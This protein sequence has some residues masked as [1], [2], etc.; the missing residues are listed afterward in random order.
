MQRCVGQ[1][2][3]EINSDDDDNKVTQHT[4]TSLSV[5]DKG[6]ILNGHVVHYTWS[7]TPL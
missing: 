3:V 1:M 7:T 4:N 2:N 5:W 6:A